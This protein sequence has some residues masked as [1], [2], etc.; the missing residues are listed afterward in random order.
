MLWDFQEVR[1]KPKAMPAPERPEHTSHVWGD[2]S[3]KDIDVVLQQD[4]NQAGPIQAGMR[5]RG[6]QGLRL[7]HQE[8]RIRHFHAVLDEYLER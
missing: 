3:E 4:G 5:S 2:G 1:R 8:R 7:A 6:F